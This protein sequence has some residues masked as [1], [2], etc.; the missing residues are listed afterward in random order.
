MELKT[1]KLSS[2]TGQY[3]RRAINE[4]VEV[5]CPYCFV[6]TCQKLGPSSEQPSSESREHSSSENS[7]FLR[8]LK[9]VVS[10]QWQTLAANLIPRQ[11][12][13]ESAQEPSELWFYLLDQYTM[14]PIILAADD[15]NSNRYPIRVSE[16]GEFIRRWLPLVTTSLSLLRGV[17]DFAG[18]AR[19]VGYPI[20][21]LTDVLDS[22]DR[23]VP[24]PNETSRSHT[25]LLLSGSS[26]MNGPETYLRGF[27]LS[28]LQAFYAQSNC[29]D[30]A[31][32]CK[33]YPVIDRDGYRCWT[34]EE[35]RDLL[36]N[37]KVPNLAGAPSSDKSEVDDEK[38]E[39]KRS[40]DGHVRDNHCLNVT[41]DCFIWE[42][43]SLL[44]TS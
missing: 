35:N 38:E 13:G 9:S 18:I 17:N 31:S 41:F 33:L 34:V 11:A 42:K 10:T 14:K 8:Y 5:Q 7:S 39:E 15:P 1:E 29:Q 26:E 40:D 20:P 12:S 4:G 2:T 16:S 23:Y 6:L 32:I 28:E 27:Q 19:L 3:T 21:D 25:N 24:K 44:V 37:Q 43:V 30:I 22:A 36:F